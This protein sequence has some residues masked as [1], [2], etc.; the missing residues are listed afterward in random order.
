MRTVEDHFIVGCYYT[1]YNYYGVAAF[2]KDGNYLWAKQS[3]L[4]G[5][6]YGLTATADSGFVL[7]GYSYVD[8]WDAQLCK[9]DKSGNV[10]WRRTYGDSLYDVFY[11]VEVTDEMVV[12]L[13]QVQL[14]ILNFHP[15]TMF[16][17]IMKTDSAGN[18]EWFYILGD[19]VI[20]RLEFIDVHQTQDGAY[21]AAGVSSYGAVDLFIAKFDANGKICAECLPADYGLDYNGS[22]FTNIT[23]GFDLETGIIED[24]IFD[25]YAGSGITTLCIDVG[26]ET[27]NEMVLMEVYPN[28]AHDF[29][30]IKSSE[31]E[32]LNMN[33]LILNI[34]GRMF[35]SVP[36]SREIN[37][38]DL[39]PE[40]YL[41][42]MQNSFL[43]FV[44]Q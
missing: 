30:Q 35:K 25:E 20:N 13:P 29:I 43:K 8:F 14:K 18:K 44:K 6:A 23:M 4:S 16:G 7:A 2:D 5:V 9:F 17:Y 39:L 22:D 24:Q 1:G 34:D 27:V 3:T 36:Y 41:L 11:S 38:S 40:I 21:V 33:V 12:L 10:E 15:T 42:R 19:P 31:K 28:P 37:I 26:I 32:I